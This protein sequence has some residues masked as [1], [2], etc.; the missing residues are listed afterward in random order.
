MVRMVHTNHFHEISLQISDPKIDISTKTI[1]LKNDH[2]QMF[3]NAVFGKQKTL[4]DAS[5]AEQNA[6]NVFR[7][8]PKS[9]R[10]K[11]DVKQHTC[12]AKRTQC[13]HVQSFLANY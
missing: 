5:R 11:S 12:F 7:N 6:L 10:T 2:V 4:R 3:G 9:F 13:F 1:C 8:I